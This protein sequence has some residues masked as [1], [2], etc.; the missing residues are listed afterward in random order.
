VAALASMIAMKP[1]IALLWRSSAS[2]PA[3]STSTRHIS[4]TSGAPARKERN[5]SSGART[6]PVKPGAD[7]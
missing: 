4:A 6:R 5:A 7:W 3:A 1:F 2:G